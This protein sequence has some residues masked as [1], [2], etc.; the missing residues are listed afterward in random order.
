MV[1]NAVGSRSRTACDASNVVALIMDLWAMTWRAM[2]LS[3]GVLTFKF[4]A[5]L[6]DAEGSVAPI[7]LTARHK[8]PG[9]ACHLVG[10]RRGSKL[11][12]LAGEQRA[13]PLGHLLAVRFTCSL[14]HRGGAGDEQAAQSLVAGPADPAQSLLAAGR[15]FFW[16]QPRPGR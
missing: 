14:D 5:T 9:D 11:A 13:Q 7:R 16:R 15:V 1:G 10:E 6:G 2:H 12:R 8:L 4:S 3:P